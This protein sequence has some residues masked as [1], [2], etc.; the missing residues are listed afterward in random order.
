MIKIAISGEAFEAIARTLPLGSVAVEPEVNERGEFAACFH[1][2]PPAGVREQGTD[3]RVRRADA[4]AVGA[5][6]TA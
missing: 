5:T 6:K 2:A 1:A 3:L 4:H